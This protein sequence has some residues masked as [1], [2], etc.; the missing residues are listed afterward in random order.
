MVRICGKNKIVSSSNPPTSANLGSHTV[1]TGAPKQSCLGKIFA[2]IAN[3]FKSLCCCSKNKVSNP[4]NPPFQPASTGRKRIVPHQEPPL[5]QEPSPSPPPSPPPSNTSSIASAAAEQYPSAPIQPE[6]PKGESPKVQTI[7]QEIL[8]P[9]PTAPKPLAEQTDL[10]EKAAFLKTQQDFIDAKIK[11]IKNRLIGIPSPGHASKIFA[12][13]SDAIKTYNSKNRDALDKYKINEIEEEKL[14]TYQTFKKEFQTLLDFWTKLIELQNACIK[15]GDLST[16]GSDIE[17]VG[18]QLSKIKDLCD[19]YPRTKKYFSESFR[20]IFDLSNATPSIEDW[21]T[22]IFQIVDDGKSEQTS[23]QKQEKVPPLS[24]PND[25]E[26]PV[27]KLTENRS[28]VVAPEPAKPSMRLSPVRMFKTYQTS[29]NA[30]LILEC[31]EALKNAI[32]LDEI[33]AILEIFSQQLKQGNEFARTQIKDLPLLPQETPQIK[34]VEESE[35]KDWWEWKQPLMIYTEAWLLLNSF[36][37]PTSTLKKA[38]EILEKIADLLPQAIPKEP[39]KCP[40]A[41]YGFMR[42]NLIT[43]YCTL[44]M[45]PFTQETIQHSGDGWKQRDHLTKALKTIAEKLN[46]DEVKY[47]LDNTE[48]QLFDAFASDAAY[49]EELDAATQNDTFQAQALLQQEILNVLD[50]RAMPPQAEI[51]RIASNSRLHPTNELLTI[52]GIWVAEQS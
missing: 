5:S 46:C 29:Y 3:F 37:T 12:E 21:K 16:F 18:Q 48:A 51:N 19:K 32:S 42:F 17:N 30:T 26:D 15:A 10:K 47:E 45:S 49:Y 41:P 43:A 20:S 9:Q 35:L 8:L 40:Y 24:P 27:K 7:V 38:I 23:G 6:P 44:S 39:N 1:R 31:K 14:P 36:S 28:K 52:L 13:F 22:K 2:A 33:N 50:G 34:D 11:D 25:R 4:S